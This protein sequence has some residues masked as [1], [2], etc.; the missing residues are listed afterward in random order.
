MLPYLLAAHGLSR[1]HFPCRCFD[2]FAKAR[3]TWNVSES[4]WRRQG[5]LGAVEPQVQRFLQARAAAQINRSFHAAAPPY[6][7]GISGSG[8]CLH[9]LDPDDAHDASHA[10]LGCTRLDGGACRA[11]HAWLHSRSCAVVNKQQPY[12]WEMGEIPVGWIIS[13]RVPFQCAHA[14]DAGSAIGKTP[15]RRFS[16]QSIA[17]ILLAPRDVRM[18]NKRHNEVIIG[19]DVFMQALPR[20]IQAKV[21]YPIACAASP[22]SSRLP[23]IG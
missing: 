19:G 20:A 2:S 17:S 13:P 15:C 7:D 14:Y 11:K 1:P 9:L 5:A 10:W 4:R 16:V 22:A 18:H 12:V 8:V 3:D 21:C 6:A 23:L